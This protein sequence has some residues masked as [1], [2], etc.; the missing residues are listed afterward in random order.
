MKKFLICSVLAFAMAASSFAGE[1]KKCEKACPKAAAA[2]E[3]AKAA[4]C[5][6]KDK[7]ASKCSGKK[8]A[9]VSKGKGAELLVQ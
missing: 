3:K 1:A 7:A 4:G 6:S 9:S 5:C 2:C 8:V